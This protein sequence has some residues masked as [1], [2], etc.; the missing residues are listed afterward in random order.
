LAVAGHGKL[1]TVPFKSMPLQIGLPERKPQWQLASVTGH[2]SFIKI[3]NSQGENGR[4]N[5]AA[6]STTSESIASF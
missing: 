4:A 3:R 2:P 6:L 1:L 5:F